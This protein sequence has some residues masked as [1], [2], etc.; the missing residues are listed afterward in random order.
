MLAGQERSR[1]AR[2]ALAQFFPRALAV[3]AAYPSAESYRI[4]LGLSMATDDWSAASAAIVAPL[5][6]DPGNDGE[7]IALFRARAF[8]SA[9]ARAKDWGRL[10]SVSTLLAAV[11]RSSP[12]TEHDLDLLRADTDLLRAVH[13]EQNLWRSAW[14]AY[15]QTPWP[16][17]A[18]E[19]IRASNNVVAI[20]DALRPDAQTAAYWSSLRV[21]DR[22]DWP[23]LVNGAAEAFRTGHHE[24]AVAILKSR[25]P[26]P[27]ERQPD[28][29]AEWLACLD[30]APPTQAAQSPAGG[31]RTA[32]EVVDDRATQGDGSAWLASNFSAGLGLPPGKPT[33]VFSAADKEP[34]LIASPRICWATR[35]TP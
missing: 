10:Q 8:V 28:F 19:R 15:K 32:V 14:A 30:G 9:A 21:G 35:T 18:F 23:V 24:E 16:E 11:P 6:F 27:G 17:P 4:L 31:D 26:G 1:D 25:S 2:R 3:Y 34:W 12:E 22:P 29:V 5:R 7:Q 20:C 33:L 13:G